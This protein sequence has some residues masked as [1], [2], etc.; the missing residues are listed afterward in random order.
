MTGDRTVET[1]ADKL[2]ESNGEVRKSEAI[3]ANIPVSNN[4]VPCLRSHILGCREEQSR[5]CNRSIGARMNNG[6]GP[7]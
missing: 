1:V 2:V 6:P 4:S 3:F 5:R 7:C